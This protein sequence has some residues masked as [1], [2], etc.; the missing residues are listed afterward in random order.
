MTTIRI[1]TQCDLK[2]VR[3]IAETSFATVRTVYRP[4]VESVHRQD[5][6]RI[7]ET[8]LVASVAQEDVGT[9]RVY[10]EENVVC[11]VG[12]AVLSSFRKR[13]VAR[14]LLDWT[15]DFAME[16][17]CTA[18]QLD[19]IRETGNVE[20]FARLG[21]QVVRESVADWCISDRFETLHNVRMIKNVGIP[22][23]SGLDK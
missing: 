13:G 8:E 14:A 12:L 3:S 4:S 15:R 6:L 7:D 5:A 20:I 22:I 18:V 2:V 9:A 1:A 17:R 10:I 21:F 19:T 16:H 23:A 11:V